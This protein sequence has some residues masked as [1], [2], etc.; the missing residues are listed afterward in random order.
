M[1]GKYPNRGL[2]SHPAFRGGDFKQR[3]QPLRNAIEV[4]VDSRAPHAPDDYAIVF[5][6]WI[7]IRWS[8]RSEFFRC[9]YK[10]RRVQRRKIVTYGVNVSL[11][12]WTPRMLRA[13]PSATRGNCG[14][15]VG[16]TATV[17]FLE[18]WTQNSTGK[19]VRQSCLLLYSQVLFFIALL[20]VTPGGPW[21]Q[22]FIHPV[23]MPLRFTPW[24]FYRA[25][26]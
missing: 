16:R 5:V 9:C 21:S 19:T 24:I 12:R 26:G 3:Q 7:D 17:Q 14:R 22:R 20:R 13:R 10:S 4:L 18:Y 15:R 11:K 1:L 25:L 6:H 2:F 23:S 8:R